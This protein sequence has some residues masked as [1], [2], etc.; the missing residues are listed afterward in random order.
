MGYE[1]VL[2]EVPVVSL[3]LYHVLYRKNES[4]EGN[5]VLVFYHD[6]HFLDVPLRRE[7]QSRSAID[8]ILVAGSPK[9]AHR[10]W[11]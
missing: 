5:L 8:G 6:Y 11:P 3:D 2:P 9:R 1:S 7:V 10:R 4:F